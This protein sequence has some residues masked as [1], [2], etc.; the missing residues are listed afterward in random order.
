MYGR[1]PSV[2]LLTNLLP[3]CSNA[4]DPERRPYVALL[5][6]LQRSSVW[7]VITCCKALG[8]IFAALVWMSGCWRMAMTIGRLL[9]LV[10][11]MGCVYSSHMHSP[12]KACCSLCNCTGYSPMPS[13]QWVGRRCP[14][15]SSCAMLRPGP[16]A[17]SKKL[18]HM[19]A[20]A[21]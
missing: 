1:Q 4:K 14:A 19:A 11:C 6:S 8:A 21:V 10:M 5:P 7:S 18:C 20:G 3:F 2:V 12:G 13:R 16:L 15:H 9:R 17:Q